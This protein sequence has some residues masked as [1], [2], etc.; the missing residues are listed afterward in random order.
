MCRARVYPPTLFPQLLPPDEPTDALCLFRRGARYFCRATQNVLQADRHGTNHYILAHHSGIVTLTG[1][2]SPERTL[3]LSQYHL[4]SVHLGWQ[5][6]P[7]QEPHTG[8]K[9]IQRVL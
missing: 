4:S 7:L 6:P 9:A 3:V 8:V 2:I 1:E 5:V